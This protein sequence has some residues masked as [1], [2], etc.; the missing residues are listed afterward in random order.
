MI[1]EWGRQLREVSGFSY[2]PPGG[3][4]SRLVMVKLFCIKLQPFRLR[5]EVLIDTRFG[6]PLALPVFEGKGGAAEAN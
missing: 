5:V 6:T 2:P 1:G 3:V 4:A